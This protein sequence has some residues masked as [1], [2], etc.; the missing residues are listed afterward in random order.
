MNGLSIK[1]FAHRGASQLAP[2]NTMPAFQL[3]YELGAEGI[4]TDIH[5]TKDLI[6][7]LIH[8]KHVK[9]TTDGIG[10]VQD[11][12]LQQLH[13]LDAGSWF[14]EQFAGERIISLEEFLQWIKPLPLTLNL[15]LKNAKAKDHQLEHIVYDMI[16]HYD[17]LERTIL[18][19]FNID[20]VMY[21][22]V[23]AGIQIAFITSKKDR[24]LINFAKDHDIHAL[25]IHYRLLKPRLMRQSRRANIPIRVYTVNKRAHILSCF[26]LQCAAIMTDMPNRAVYERQRIF[27]F[28]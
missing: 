28:E 14:S 16:T 27:G 8:D 1:I 13:Q 12:T 23:L 10:T 26:K 6:P 9:R 17:L 4:E 18:S 7:V 24:Q 5:L 3:A 22:K 25:H 11:Y 20:S 21:M 2:E 15:E 19:T